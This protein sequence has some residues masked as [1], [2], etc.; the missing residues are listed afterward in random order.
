MAETKSLKIFLS[1]AAEQLTLA[2]RLCLSLLS[3]GHEVFFDRTS[4]APGT[5]FN[6]II[7]SQIRHSDLLIYLISPQSVGD[8]AYA[9][10]EL[11]FAQAVWPAPQGHVLPVMAKPTPMEDVPNYLRAV[12]VL[13]PHGDMVAEVSAAI[14]DIATGWKPEYTVLAQGRSLEDA[15]REIARL[16]VDK[17]L[18]LLDER[19]IKKWGSSIVSGNHFTGAAVFIVVFA[20]FSTFVASN[21]FRFFAP[22]WSVQMVGCACAA[23]YCFH[24]KNE[25]SRDEAEYR[26]ERARLCQAEQENLGDDEHVLRWLSHLEKAEQP[27]LHLASEIVKLYGSNT[28]E[29]STSG[30]KNRS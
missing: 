5:D 11:K 25:F 9:R 14:R 13:A 10:T 22:I 4:I 23:V 20:G 30:D 8:G 19:W 2:E 16:V 18:K 3:G 27:D 29:D 28:S 1:Y 7:L 24:K 6:E 17:Q 15:K 12:S 26:R 21:S